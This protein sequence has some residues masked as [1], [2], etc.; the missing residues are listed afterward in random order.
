MAQSKTRGGSLKL[1]RTD[2]VSVELD[3]DSFLNNLDYQFFFF[4][5]LVFSSFTLVVSGTEI[6]GPFLL[7]QLST[8]TVIEH[9]SSF[10]LVS[11]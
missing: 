7:S 3:P 9:L 8:V 4:F 1:S 2:H 5:F 10:R 11:S 6:I